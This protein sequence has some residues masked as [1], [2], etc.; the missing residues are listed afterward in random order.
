MTSPSE[1]APIS[2]VQV[3]DLEDGRVGDQV[4]VLAA[5]LV[6]KGQRVSVAGQMNK[7]LQERL[8][9]LGVRWSVLPWPEEERG[10]SLRTA[11]RQLARL[12]VTRPV[13]LL[14][15]HGFTA[16]RIA[17]EALRLLASDRPRLV[18][19]LYDLPQQMD[20]LQR[21]R[22]P[23]ALRRAPVPGATVLV[24][25]QAEHEA[26]VALVGSLAAGA[27]VVYPA[28]PDVSRPSGVEAG[29]LRRRLGLRGDAAVVGLRTAF[30]D[31]E[32]ATLLQAAARVHEALPNVEFVLLGEGPR[33][34][35]A[36]EYAHQLGLSG[37]TVFLGRPRSM[38]EAI[39]VLNA[40]ALVS[41]ADAAH[42]DALQALGYG[43][44]VIAP[45]GGVLAELLAGVARVHLVPAED[46][47]ALAGALQAVL[48]LVPAGEVG[49][50][51]E[52]ESGRFAGLEQF[53]VSR[54]FWDLDQP[55]QR[56]AHRPEPH[57]AELEGP[58]RRFLPEAVAAR[59]LGVYRT[60]LGQ[61]DRATRDGG[62]KASAGRSGRH[63]A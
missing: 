56:T 57:G 26:L 11:V 7:R 21:R 14:H 34:P 43:L 2:V 29:L 15:V 60:V 63:G 61:E 50:S 45:Q 47:E 37:G 35:E 13:D 46:P 1:A 6:E 52:T 30:Q 24:A 48:H 9:R 49:E 54:E 31:T 19:S 18:A 25:S 17:V 20:R 32:Y 51:V 58:L 33:L 22:L 59:V 10:A 38:G 3:A 4:L 28:V 39:S 27:Q 53:L 5:G 8:R 23:Q 55:W 42:L 12:L 41:D 40:L 36:R 44:P 16:L 62:G